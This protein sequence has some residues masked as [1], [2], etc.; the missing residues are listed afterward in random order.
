M[1]TDRAR[2]HRHGDE[3]KTNQVNLKMTN[4]DLDLLKRASEALGISMNG[5]V[6]ILSTKAARE[7]LRESTRGP[8]AG[9][10]SVGG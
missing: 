4:T 7:L 9:R 5:T 6:T 8:L 10:L 3:K 2:Q 1:A